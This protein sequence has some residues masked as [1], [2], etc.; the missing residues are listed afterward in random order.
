[1]IFSCSSAE[2]EECRALL[3]SELTALSKRKRL[4][5]PT[6]DRTETERELW[7]G[8][9]TDEC[10]ERGSSWF[11]VGM[12]EVSRRWRVL[13]LADL[14]RFVCRGFCVAI[15][16]RRR[17]LAL[18]WHGMEARIVD[19]DRSLSSSSAPYLLTLT[20][21]PRSS[22]KAPKDYLFIDRKLETPTSRATRPA[23][24]S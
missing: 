20:C 11:V 8:D 16:Q 13:A 9:L 14:V 23:S 1:M 4:R 17:R 12:R 5:Y 24:S 2:T 22:F 21:S 19:V 7:Y 3:R 18:C 15:G 6:V 10:E